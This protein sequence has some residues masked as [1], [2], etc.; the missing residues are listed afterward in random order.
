MSVPIGT[1]TSSLV[2]TFDFQGK[3]EEIVWDIELEEKAYVEK[4]FDI[5]L[6]SELS[7]NIDELI[8]EKVPSKENALKTI[9]ELID[10][11]KQLEEKANNQNN[12]L[13]GISTT[14]EISERIQKK[15]A[16]VEQKLNEKKK[17]KET[18]MCAMF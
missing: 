2:L 10:S 4:C 11:V 18:I 7:W 13:F 9:N 15:L 17:S 8:P 6:M 3:K 14:G 16:L 12:Y 1:S 5:S